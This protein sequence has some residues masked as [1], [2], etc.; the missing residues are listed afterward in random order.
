MSWFE[1]QVAARRPAAVGSFHLELAVPPAVQASYVAPGQYV[2]LRPPGVPEG[3]FAL[4]QAP[5]GSGPFE[6]L[7][8]EGTPMAAAL[9][10]LPLGAAVEVTRAQ[11]RGFALD[12]AHGRDL[13][14][15][16]TGTGLAP[17]RA[18]LGH[19]LRNRPRFGAVV[20]LHG[21]FTPAHFMWNDELPA[22]TAAGV[23]VERIVSE[24]SPGW[25]GPRG[26]VQRLLE[27]EDLARAAVLVVGQRELVTELQASLPARG[28]PP[29]LV[30]TNF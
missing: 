2:Q 10:A 12:R 6:L 5:G 30:L 22:W 18:V 11:G 21:V 7:V 15:V 1:A 24:E 9:Q 17:L 4:A 25:S 27:R 13:V 29:E 26:F 20:L 8:K 16:G 3:F 28:V 19:V 14:L 23:R